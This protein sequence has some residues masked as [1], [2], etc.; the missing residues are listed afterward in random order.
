[1]SKSIKQTIAIKAIHPELAISSDLENSKANI[2]ELS[3][4]YSLG[5]LNYFTYKNEPRGYYLSITPIERSEHGMFI[6]SGYLFGT[7]IK[8]FL[9]EVSRQSEK[10]MAIAC[11]IAEQE[12]ERMVKWCCEQYG[13]EVDMPDAY[14]PNAAKAKVPIKPV[15]VSAPKE[16]KPDPEPKPIRSM[17]LLTADIIRKLEKHPFGSQDAKG[18]DA[19]VIVKFFGGGA[20]TWLITEGEKQEDGD[21]MLYGKATLGYD[22]EWGYVM[23]SELEKMTFPPFGLGVE[24]DMYLESNATVGKLCA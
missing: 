1:M 2:L 6:S 13:L 21:W 15:K 8:T 3:V 5:G 22:W 19:Q 11:A 9:L 14:F 12:A 23:L 7:G 24:R 16:K 17:K 18:D 20:A 10:Q 4:Y